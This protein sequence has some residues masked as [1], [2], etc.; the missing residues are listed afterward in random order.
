[1]VKL[2]LLVDLIVVDGDLSV[3]I[4]VVCYI[5]VVIKGGNLVFMIW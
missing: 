1:M 3:D 2:G 5:C 4:C